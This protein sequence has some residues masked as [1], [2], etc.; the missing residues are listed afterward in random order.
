VWKA[1]RS[2]P[3]GIDNGDIDEDF[4]TGDV[5]FDGLNMIVVTRT[6]KLYRVA[7]SAAR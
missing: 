3:L 4:R 6:G 5:L 1:T 2:I 7:N